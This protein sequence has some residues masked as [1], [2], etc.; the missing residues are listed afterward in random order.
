M[1]VREILASPELITNFDFFNDTKDTVSWLRGVNTPESM[2]L[3]VELSAASAAWYQKKFTN[4]KS[5]V[6]CDAWIA[7][8]RL[9]IFPWAVRCTK[10]AAAN[11]EPLRHDPNVECD[12]GSASARNG[13][14]KND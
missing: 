14:G 11:P 2:A 10:C 9:E 5:C 6:V 13:W 12:I 3:A 4:R 7:L 8:E 1:I